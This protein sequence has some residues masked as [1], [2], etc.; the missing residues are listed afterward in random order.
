[1]KKESARRAA[2]FADEDPLV[3]YFQ[4]IKDT[5][6]LTSQREK[7]LAA[8]I[9]GGDRG[10]LNELVQANLKFVVA[11]CRQYENRG[12]PL[13]DLI[14][15]GNLG[16]IRAAERFDENRECRF[17]SYAVWWI[18]Q[19]VMTALADQS[20]SVRISTSTAGRMRHVAA[21]ARKL[22]QRLG[23][24]PSVEELE[25]ETGLQAGG[26]RA[27]LRLLAPAASAETRPENLEAGASDSTESAAERFH[28]KRAMDQVL[29][30]LDAREREVVDLYFGLRHGEAWNL[31][32]MARK[33]G[34]SKERVRQIKEKA[35]AKL[36]VFL[37]LNAKYPC[38]TIGL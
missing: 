11:V 38:A 27:Y 1:M 17:I 23:R 36:K 31:P 34:L 22:G 15:E 35:I 7:E 29:K 12:L 8:R 2:F 32:R 13:A 14:S 3:A 28:T 10:A 18:R 4:D 25:L 9:R 20:R 16:L 24:E 21:A 5:H 33:L 6:K 30:R 37:L 19:A 26:I